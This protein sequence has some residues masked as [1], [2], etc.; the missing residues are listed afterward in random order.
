MSKALLR[1]DNEFAEI[2]ERHVQTIWHICLA[3]MKNKDDAQD[4]VQETF[5]KLYRY[6]GSFTGTEHEKAWLIVTASNQCRDMLKHWWRKREDIDAHLDLTARETCEIDNT[7][8]EVMRLPDKYKTVIY[9]YY[10]EGYSSIEIG[11]ILQKPDSTIR[12]YLSRAK[13]ILRSRLGG[14]FD[15]E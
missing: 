7:L 4:A 2:Y 6:Q 13:K 8:E 3:Y 14:G 11:K 9:L 12:N 1:N 10:Y 15:E 5:L